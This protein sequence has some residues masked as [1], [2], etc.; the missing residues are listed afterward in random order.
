MEWKPILKPTWNGNPT[1]KPTWNGN[2]TLKP[3]RNRRCF[4]CWLL[5]IGRFGAWLGFRWKMIQNPPMSH[6]S[7]TE[8]IVIENLKKDNVYCRSF[9]LF[10]RSFI[11]VATFQYI[12]PSPPNFDAPPIFS[13][14]HPFEQKSDI[15]TNRKNHRFH[16]LKSNLS[17][18]EHLNS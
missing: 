6:V 1:L 13:P 15:N 9:K 10:F 2:P 16:L 14:S 8:P 5:W 18:T 4:V 17:V 11:S 12:P 7:F 3:T